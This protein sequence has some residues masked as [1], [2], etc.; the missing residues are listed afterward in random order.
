[1]AKSTGEPA[2]GVTLFDTSKVLAGALS[3][4]AGLFLFWLLTMFLLVRMRR[5]TLPAVFAN[6]VF[7]IL[8]FLAAQRG[9]QI[10][11]ARYFAWTFFFSILWNILELG[12]LSTN[13]LQSRL[14]S[15]FA[16]C[17]LALLLLALPYE[18]RALY[19]MLKSRSTLLP[20]FE[21]EHL[22]R[23]EGKRGVAVD[24]GLIGYFSRADIC[25][26]AGLVNGREKA[27]E[28]ATE[29]I[30]GCV[31]SHPDFLFFDAATINDVRPYLSPSDWQVCSS[32]DFNNVHSSNRHY[33]LVPRVT[34][35]EECKEISNSAPS[36]VE[37]F[38]N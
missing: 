36:E 8:L 2:W 27:R 28:T 16:Y 33:L 29:R 35:V 38:L 14:G 31:A 15:A 4:G 24:V 10:Q 6:S 25:D 22:E 18:S 12:R 5:F 7:P 37:A 34:A 20:Q 30:T 32:Y 9:Q 17:F 3:F 21:S 1:L 13:P 23:F 19:P 26:L 11:G